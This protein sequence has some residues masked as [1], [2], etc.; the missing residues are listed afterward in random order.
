M[1]MA[2]RKWKVIGPKGCVVTSAASRQSQTITD[3]PRGTELVGTGNEEGDRIEIE[4]PSELQKSGRRTGW[5]SLRRAGDN[6]TLVV[7]V[8]A[9][10]V[11]S[12][13]NSPNNSMRASNSM[14]G[15]AA[16]EAGFGSIR[17]GSP[18]GMCGYKPGETVW[19]LIN[20]QQNGEIIVPKGAEGEVVKRHQST[21]GKLGVRF[22]GRLCNVFA[23]SITNKLSAAPNKHQLSSVPS[24]R[25]SHRPDSSKSSRST[26]DTISNAS[27]SHNNGRGTSHQPRHTNN[28]YRSEYN[29]HNSHNRYHS[30][31]NNN[32]KSGYT[33]AG[34]RNSKSGGGGG[35]NSNDDIDPIQQLLERDPTASRIVASLSAKYISGVLDDVGYEEALESVLGEGFRDAIRQRVS[36]ER[37]RGGVSPSPYRGASIPSPH[38]P[39]HQVSVPRY[40][41]SVDYYDQPSHRASPSPMDI[42]PPYH[43]DFP[44][45]TPTSVQREVARLQ[46]T[47]P[48][49]FK[50]FQDI[51]KGY[52]AGTLPA[53]KYRLALSELFGQAA[54]PA[55]SRAGGYDGHGTPRRVSPPR[56]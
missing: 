6:L 43:D 13:M 46:D 33:S 15:P 1:S 53:D 47:D 40:G 22:S 25:N 52:L 50:I 36:A 37:P 10:Y 32:N 18:D 9:T 39:Q 19:S 51:S 38:L 49:K 48:A 12:P 14:A 7:P 20:I 45:Q 17:S 54:S 34:H 2:T 29:N 41:P 23:T 56:R 24:N 16:S 5:V 4:I 3:I 26:S 44:A 27:T 21:Y 42:V 30:T 8:T 55:R 28:V 31:S 35:Y 11:K